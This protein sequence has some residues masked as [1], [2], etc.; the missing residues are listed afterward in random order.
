MEQIRES[1]GRMPSQVAADSGYARRENILAMQGSSEFIYPVG[2]YAQ[3]RCAGQQARWGVADEFTAE[4]FL[5]DAEQDRYRCPAGK[6]LPY[7]K[8]EWMVG[9]KARY[10]RAN[11]ADCRGCPNKAR[12]CPKVPSRRIRQ[13]STDPAIA[14]HQARMETAEARHIYRQRAQVAEFPNAW[15]KAK[16]NLRQFQLRGRAKVTMETLWAALTYNIQQWI[17]LCWRA[18]LEKATTG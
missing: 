6:Q 5:Y 15:I 13:V 14:E 3:N 11:P 16:I 12:C 4:H 9:A 17:R 2:D 18:A 1:F 7:Y 10:Y 8:I